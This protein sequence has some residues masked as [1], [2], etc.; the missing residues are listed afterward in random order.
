LFPEQKI[1]Q[2]VSGKIPDPISGRIASL[3]KLATLL[4]YPDPAPEPE[5]SL[6]GDHLPAFLALIAVALPLEL[7]VL[8]PGEAE[9]FS[10]LLSPSIVAVAVAMTPVVSLILGQLG[11]DDTDGGE[12][13][14]SVVGWEDGYRDGSGWGKCRCIRV[15]ARGV[16]SP[17]LTWLWNSWWGNSWWRN[18]P[19]DGV[20]RDWSR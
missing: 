6:D 13:P 10:L 20:Q 19:D 18:D 3:T 15:L 5:L 16:A 11:E 2:A 9:Q 12:R 7:L 4:N 14:G 1:R 17:E 8:P